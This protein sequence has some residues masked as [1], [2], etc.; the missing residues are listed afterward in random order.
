[1]NGPKSLVTHLVKSLL[2]AE[3][4]NLIVCEGAKNRI[5]DDEEAQNSKE[6]MA[7]IL[8]DRIKAMVKQGHNDD[9]KENLNFKLFDMNL[10]I[11]ADTN[12]SVTDLDMSERL[13]R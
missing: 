1:M 6:S 12:V 5:V 3:H 7:T 4:L 9:M 11:C 13:S 8:M 10:M 2:A